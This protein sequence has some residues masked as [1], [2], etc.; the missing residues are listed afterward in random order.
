MLAKLGLSVDDVARKLAKLPPIVAA[1]VW[2]VVRGTVTADTIRL[3][4]NASKADWDQ[5]DVLRIIGGGDPE[6]VKEL[7]EIG[8]ELA[9][10]EMFG[11]DNDKPAVVH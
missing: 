6:A 8:W 2:D 10:A 11:G 7:A 4:Q 5:Y 9:V 3:A 1:V